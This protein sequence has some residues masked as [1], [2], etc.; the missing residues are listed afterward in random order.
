MAVRNKNILYG[1]RY[2]EN[3]TVLMTRNTDVTRLV[4]VQ[5]VWSVRE[6]LDYLPT[7]LL[8]IIHDYN[9]ELLVVL[10]HI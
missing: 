9:K 10:K 5:K 8:N 1:K 4:C 6:F 2:F 7:V 3:I